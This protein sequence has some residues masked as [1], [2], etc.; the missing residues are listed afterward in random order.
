MKEK[1]TLG[2]VTDAATL[3]GSGVLGVL[4]ISSIYSS[5]TNKKGAGA[6]AVGGLTL[7]ISIAAFKYSLSELNNK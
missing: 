7:L 2:T 4:A 1:S 6:I 5:F 3:L